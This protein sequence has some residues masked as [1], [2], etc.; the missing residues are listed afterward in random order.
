M[1]IDCSMSMEG[2]RIGTVNTTMKELLKEME[3]MGEADSELKV[4]ILKFSS[5]CQW[6]EQKLINPAELANSWTKLVAD[7]VTDMG[8]AFLELNAR[9]S[10]NQ[11]LQS[12][13]STFAPIIILIT[14]GEPT[15]DYKKGLAAL[16]E[17]NWFINAMRIALPVDEGCNMDVLHEF[18]NNK[19]LVLKPV[20]SAA[21]LRAM[22]RGVV[23]TASKIGSQSSTGDKSKIDQLGTKLIDIQNDP[24]PDPFGLSVSGGGDWG[25]INWDEQAVPGPNPGVDPDPEW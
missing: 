14:D 15:D 3:D 24:E 6:M 1:L 22:L 12:P 16:K 8:A 19:E 21:Q 2:A 20:T 4:A 9:L 18:A 5:G 11:F 17:N 23:V 7:G 13:S 25:E 10:R